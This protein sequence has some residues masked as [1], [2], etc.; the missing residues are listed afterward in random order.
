M[1]RSIENLLEE[2]LKKHLGEALPAHA[3]DTINAALEL[4]KIMETRGFSFQLKDL[5]PKSR[6]QTQWRAVFLK[7]G[8]EFSAD[9][10]HAPLA[11]C[12]AAV[13]ALTNQ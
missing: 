6:N 1:S 4:S 12:T 3:A 7:D 11:V 8:Q 5:C 2:Q 9:Q 13:A 10:T